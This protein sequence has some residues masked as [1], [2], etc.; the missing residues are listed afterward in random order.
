[1]EETRAAKSKV[2]PRCELFFIFFIYFY[3]AALPSSTQR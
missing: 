3:C 1:M 2:N